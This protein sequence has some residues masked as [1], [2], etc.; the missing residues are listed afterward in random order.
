MFRDNTVQL[1]CSVP[2]ECEGTNLT[3]Q[4]WSKEVWLWLIFSLIF[5]GAHPSDVAS[6]RIGGT[7]SG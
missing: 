1:E 2:S 4:D 5:L 6:Y 7:T 3:V